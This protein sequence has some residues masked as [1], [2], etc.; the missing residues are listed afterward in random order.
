MISGLMGWSNHWTKYYMKVIAPP[1][2]L[3]K[4]FC[5]HILI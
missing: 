4:Y 5:I 2:F 1:L 3:G